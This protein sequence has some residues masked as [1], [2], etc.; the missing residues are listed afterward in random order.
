MFGTL[1]ITSALHELSQPK[2]D[3]LTQR[4]LYAYGFL[5]SLL[6][7]HSPVVRRSEVQWNHYPSAKLAFVALFSPNYFPLHS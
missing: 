2:E 3:I 7:V 1:Y 6:A 5:C 4:I